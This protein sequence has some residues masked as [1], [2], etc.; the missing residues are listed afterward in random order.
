MCLL[1]MPAAE[2]MVLVP[3]G[4]RCMCEDCW[5]TQL[6]PRAPTA[7]LCPLCDARVATAV[8]LVAGVF[9]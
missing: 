9:D 8:R 3:C 4:H 2:Q 1:D 6:A 7:R 5:H